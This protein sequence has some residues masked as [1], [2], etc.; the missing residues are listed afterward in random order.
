MI[1]VEIIWQLCTCKDCSP[2]H[3]LV[4]TENPLRLMLKNAAF[5]FHTKP[6]KL[7][8]SMACNSHDT[9]YPP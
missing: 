6:P 1:W 4:A 8:R 9:D 5:Q 3:H 2:T 7:A